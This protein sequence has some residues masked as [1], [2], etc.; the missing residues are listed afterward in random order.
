AGETV[1]GS[2]S[3]VGSITGGT[4]TTG[5][6]DANGQCTLIVN[7]AVTGTATVSAS[8][9]VVV[10]DLTLNRTTNGTGGSSGP[11]TKTW[12]AARISIGPPGVNR[13]GQPP[14]FTV[15]VEENARGGCRRPPVRR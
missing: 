4:C 8:A 13:V 15:T 11:A 14:T 7:S 5:T 12:V 10:G 9:G 1:T 6:T 2:L 3:G